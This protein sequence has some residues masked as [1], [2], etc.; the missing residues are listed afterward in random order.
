MLYSISLRFVV[1]GS[2]TVLEN[3]YQSAGVKRLGITD[4]NN[5]NYNAVVE[6]ARV[7]KGIIQSTFTPAHLP[8]NGGNQQLT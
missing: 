6:Q 2:R 7:R 1:A 3:F 4:L 8:I 5:R